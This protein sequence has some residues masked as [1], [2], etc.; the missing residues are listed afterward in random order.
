MSSDVEMS[1]YLHEFEPRDWT[2]AQLGLRVTASQGR[3]EYGLRYDVPPA[4]AP[5]L[6]TWLTADGQR[7]RRDAFAGGMTIKDLD[8]T[9]TY[10]LALRNVRDQSVEFV[11]HRQFPAGFQ[12]KVA[13]GQVASLLAAP[14]VLA[15]ADVPGELLVVAP[16]G[17]DLALVGSEEPQ[18]ALA[19]GYALIESVKAGPRGLS[20]M[21]YRVVDGSRLEP[22]IPEAGSP[23][24]PLYERARQVELERR[25]GPM[26]QYEKIG[27]YTLQGQAF[28]D[29][30]T[31]AA[32]PRWAYDAEANRLVSY[33]VWQ[34]S[35]YPGLI[36]PVD[37]VAVNVRTSRSAPQ[38]WIPVAKLAEI[39]GV[40]VAETT[41]FGLPLTVVNWPGGSEGGA[42]PEVL[43]KP[44]KAAG[45]RTAAQLRVPKE[46]AH[47]LDWMPAGSRFTR[48]DEFPELLLP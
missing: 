24:R 17:D 40:E 2:V 13:S 29:S 11:P 27:H 47:I 36:P 35:R 41:E 3:P 6:T 14:D 5:L 22:W 16:T 48:V 42:D 30:R 4:P 39:A 7:F 8:F 18:L 37:W 43:L 23:L 38:A 33:C 19:Y 32:P 28:E 10:A 46:P 15:E 12:V 44:V 34:P 21:I 9:E 25:Y 1:A 20:P 45:G 31:E 26:L